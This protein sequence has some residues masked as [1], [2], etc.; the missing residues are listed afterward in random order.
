MFPD[1][2]LRIY[3]LHCVLLHKL[4]HKLLLWKDES[5]T[6]GDIILQFINPEAS[7]LP[8]LYYDFVSDF[9]RVT[10]MLKVDRV[11]K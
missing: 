9:P 5:T 8:S 6:I 10:K 1:Q 2:L 11:Y 4:E 3:E 7:N